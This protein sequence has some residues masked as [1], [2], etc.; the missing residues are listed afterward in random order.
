MRLLAPRRTGASAG[1]SPIASYAQWRAGFDATG[2]RRATWICGDQ[3]VLVEEVVDTIRAHLG[4][5]ELD[6]VSLSASPTFERDVWAAANQYPLNPGSPRL[7]L[8]RDAQKLTRWEQL[9]RWLARTRQLPGVHLVLVSADADLPTT[10]KRTLAPHAAALKAP[11][12][13]LVRASL[14]APADLLAWVHRRARIDDTTALYLLE[15]TGGDLALA[16]AVCAKLSLFAGAAGRTAIDAL[17]AE[18]PATDFTA[19]LLALDKRRA[20]LCIPDLTDAETTR[21]IGLLDS[22]LD[23]LSALHRIQ[24]AGQ[25]YRDAVGINPYLVRAYLPLARHYDPKRCV[26]RRRVLAVVDDAFRS[27]ARTGVLESLVSL[28]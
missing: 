24:L 7:V 15:R 26:Y 27:G 18:R 12:G 6:Y 13:T 19:C 25:S 3:R 16:A 1:L 9:H 14:P 17:V 2:V 8:I 20:L 21:T 10:G 23:L 4:V 28:W 22:R 11:R 5:A